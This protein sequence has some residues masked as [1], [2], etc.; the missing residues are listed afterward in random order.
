MVEKAVEYERHDTQMTELEIEKRVRK[1]W[2]DVEVEK[3]EK[4][5]K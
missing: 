4:R 3:E 1:V 5:D 2:R